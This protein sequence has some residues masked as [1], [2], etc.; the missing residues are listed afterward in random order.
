MTTERNSLF[1]LALV[2]QLHH[3]DE[4][5]ARQ[6]VLV[7]TGA[8]GVD[9]VDD[10]NV[11]TDTGWFQ[12][13]STRMPTSEDLE[14]LQKTVGKVDAGSLDPPSNWDPVQDA[15]VAQKHELRDGH[16]ERDAVVQSFLASASNRNVKVVKVERIQ[17]LSMYQSYVVKRSVR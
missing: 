10:A 7:A 2:F 14:A 13:E 17:N 1:L 5:I 4:G 8:V 6:L 11:F 16:P 15:T 12:L 3:A 9:E